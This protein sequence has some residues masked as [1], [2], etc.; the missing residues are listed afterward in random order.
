VEGGRM[1]PMMSLFGLANGSGDGE[2]SR[3]NPQWPRFQVSVDPIEP[4]HEKLVT[5]SVSA[6]NR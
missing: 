4:D 5:L 1:R 2:E 6:L 3:G